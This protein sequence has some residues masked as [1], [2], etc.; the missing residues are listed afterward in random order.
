MSRTVRPCQ[1]RSTVAPM[2]TRSKDRMRLPALRAFTSGWRRDRPGDG[3][4]EE[5]RSTTPAGRRPSIRRLGS[6]TSSSTRAWTWKRRLAPASRSSTGLAFPGHRPQDVARVPGGRG[7]VA[8]GSGLGVG[9]SHAPHLPFRSEAVRGHQRM[10]VPQGPFPGPGVAHD[11][12]GG[13]EA[14][15]GP[16][17]TGRTGASPGRRWWRT[18][19]RRRAWCG[20]APAAGP[21]RAAGR[22]AARRVLGGVEDERHLEGVDGAQ[23]G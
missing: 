5:S 16:A 4:D 7:S 23:P 6:V 11:L 12:R 13:V 20:R 8:R 10:P 2:S 9:W 19:P 18:R 22:T 1:C 14:H 15:R 17:V 21:G 3:G